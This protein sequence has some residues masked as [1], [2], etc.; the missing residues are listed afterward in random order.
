MAFKQANHSADWY[1]GGGPEEGLRYC[2]ADGLSYVCGVSWGR[3][4]Q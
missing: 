1:V 2:F 4:G 3:K